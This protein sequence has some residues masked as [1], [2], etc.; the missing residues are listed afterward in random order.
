MKKI[1]V[2]KVEEKLLLEVKTRLSLCDALVICHHHDKVI[3]S[4][5]ENLQ[6]Y[7]AN[8]LSPHSIKINS[9]EDPANM[10][11][12]DCWSFACSLS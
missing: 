5:H 3:L 9:K 7:S 11:M 6:K 1:S 10:D 8:L 12:Q 4:K 2:N